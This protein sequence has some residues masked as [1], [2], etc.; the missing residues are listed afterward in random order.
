MRDGASLRTID[1]DDAGVVTSGGYGPT[2]GGPVAMGYVPVAFA[3]TGRV[4]VAD[5]RGSEVE[6]VVAELPFS[7]H[8]Y[9]RGT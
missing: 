1:G 6:L 2:I 5:V 4:L 3:D 9:H 8:R 7:P